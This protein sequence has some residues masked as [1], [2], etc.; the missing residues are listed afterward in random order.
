MASVHSGK[1]ITLYGAGCLNIVFSPPLSLVEMAS[2]CHELFLRGD[3]TSG[4]YTIQ[5]V[6]AEP[7]KVFCEMKTGKWRETF[8]PAGL[9]TIANYLDNQSLT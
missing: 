8:F 9:P 6:N 4:V 2:D 7:F 3:T 5:P 1:V